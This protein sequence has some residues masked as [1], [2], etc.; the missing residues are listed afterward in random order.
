MQNQSVNQS[1]NHQTKRNSYANYGKQL[2]NSV[3]GQQPHQQQQIWPSSLPTG[4]RREEC[5]RPNGLGT[6]K[7]D[8]YYISPQNQVVRNKQ[9]MQTLL[10]DKYDIGLF[11][12]RMGKFVMSN[13]NSNNNTNKSKRLE[14]P[15]ADTSSASSPSAKD[16]QCSLPMRRCPFPI[17]N[18]VKPVILFWE[19]RLA[20]HVAIDPDTGESFKPL[21]LPKGIQSAGV[22]GYQP[23]QLVHSLIHAL[24]SS[25]SKIS[26]IIGQEQQ[27]SAIE[28]N[29]CVVINHLQPMIKTFIVTDDDIRRQEARVKELRKKLEIAR[30]KLHPVSGLFLCSMKKSV[31]V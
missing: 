18:D 29:P 22:P 8:V 23:V 7:S 25:S 26:P 28:K 24:S 15:T 21:F 3:S 16:N 11:D 5:M 17:T 4:W 30:K 6:G 9:E 12:W 31:K 1:N 13:N 27:P 14:E 20:D 2:Q 10:G 19:K